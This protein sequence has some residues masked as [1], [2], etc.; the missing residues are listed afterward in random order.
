M[1]TLPRLRTRHLA[2][3]AL[4]AV[5]SLAA[6]CQPVDDGLSDAEEAGLLWVREEEKLAR[7]VYLALGEQWDATVFANI[8]VSDQAHMDAMLDLLVAYDLDDPAA[9]QPEGSFTDPEL[10]ALYDSLMAKGSTSLIAALEVGATIEDLDIL[11]LT[12]RAAETDEADIQS[13]YANLTDGSRNHLQAFVRQLTAR[14]VTYTPVYITQA[15][16]DAIIAG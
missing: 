12:T 14:G 10:Q 8:A 15:E 11:D 4:L 5:S 16:F 2:L 7:D 3:A 1:S 6:S 13:V 9:G